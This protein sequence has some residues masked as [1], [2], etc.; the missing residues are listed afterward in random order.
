MASASE[1]GTVAVHDLTR[2]LSADSASGVVNALSPFRTLKAH[3][4]SVTSV[5]WSSDQTL[6]LATASADGT[7]L[8][9]DVEEGSITNTLLGHLGKVFT[10]VWSLTDPESVF[11]GSEDQTVRAWNLTEAKNQGSSLFDF[12]VGS[13]GSNAWCR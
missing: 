4:K 13:I 5:S 12:F 1:D 9:W 10:V 11:T 7:A 6:R 3:T 8:I 2:I